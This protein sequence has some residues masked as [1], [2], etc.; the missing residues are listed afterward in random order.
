MGS[1]IPTCQTQGCNHRCEKPSPCWVLW[2][3]C[4]LVHSVCRGFLHLWAWRYKLQIRCRNAKIIINSCT[5]WLTPEFWIK[6]GIRLKSPFLN[7]FFPSLATRST[8]TAFCKINNQ[9]MAWQLQFSVS[10][11]SSR[12]CQFSSP[13]ICQSGANRSAEMCISLWRSGMPSVVNVKAFVETWQAV[14]H[15]QVKSRAEYRSE[16]ARHASGM[17]L[18]CGNQ[19]DRHLHASPLEFSK[20]DWGLVTLEEIWTK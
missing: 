7:V 18:M 14:S 12:C 2:L 3:H 17:M 9:H 13:D 1:H 16:K 20:F 6:L 8:S 15:E 5:F 10:V 19:R 4:M 11:V